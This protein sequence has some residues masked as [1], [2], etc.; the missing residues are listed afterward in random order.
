MTTQLEVLYKI[1]MATYTKG[2]QALLDRS[3][4]YFYH[5]CKNHVSSL[6]D[7][8]IMLLQEMTIDDTND[9]FFS[10]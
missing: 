4:S 9:G 2:V 8:Y 6:D 3:C 1:Q 7:W 5:E 10:S